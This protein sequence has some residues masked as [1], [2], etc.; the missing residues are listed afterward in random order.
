M[1]QCSKCQQIKDTTEFSKCQSNKNGLYSQCKE[2]VRVYQKTH[3]KKNHEKYLQKNTLNYKMYGSRWK[4][5]RKKYNL[6]H[7]EHLYKKAIERLQNPR[8]RKMRN[9]TSSKRDKWRRINDPIY[10]IKKT[11]RTRVWNAL[12]GIY[13][14]HHT[15]ELVG[16]SFSEL[17]SKLESRFSFGMSW[18][19]YGEW[20]VDHI[21]PCSMFDLTKENE[22]KK[23]FH[24]SN[25]QPLWAKDNLRKNNKVI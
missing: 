13:K 18:D 5:T 22:Q 12:K 17:K 16:C 9:I 3:Y 23:C 8:K 4:Q 10:R 15:E 24:Y 14:H 1:K 11:I 20:H 7:R 2:C 25:L 6:E 21:I 19:N